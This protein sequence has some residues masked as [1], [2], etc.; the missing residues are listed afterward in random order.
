MNVDCFSGF[1]GRVNIIL[2]SFLSVLEPDLV[3]IS[4]LPSL[5]KDKL[6]VCS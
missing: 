4:S 2:F 6:K 5:C 1:S 3:V